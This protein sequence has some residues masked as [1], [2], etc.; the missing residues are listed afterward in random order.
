MESQ[1]NKEIIERRKF[2]AKCAI[3]R[4]NFLISEIENISD[5]EDI[6]TEQRDF[7]ED[8]FNKILI[9]DFTAF[10]VSI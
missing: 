10:I 2:R 6:Q 8:Y 7:L 1:V 5:S 4:L 9:K 3:R